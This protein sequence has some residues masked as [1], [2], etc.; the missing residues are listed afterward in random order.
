MTE[1]K[2]FW[3]NGEI[4][5]KRR[6]RPERNGR[7]RKTREEPKEVV[8]GLV[9]DD[10]LGRKSLYSLTL[11][12]FSNRDSGGGPSGESVSIHE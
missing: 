8:R 6:W 12:K 3:T 9:K 5:L 4:R 11:R 1:I 10:R 2:D 7:V